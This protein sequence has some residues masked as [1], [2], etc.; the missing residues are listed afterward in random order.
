MA[1]A[2]RAAG[3][4]IPSSTVFEPSFGGHAPF[5]SCNKPPRHLPAPPSVTQGI[6]PLKL[7]HCRTQL[8]AIGEPGE[9]LQCLV[10]RC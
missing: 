6:D 2:R 8:V 4:P 1:T 7:G 3:K 10:D 9:T 5:S